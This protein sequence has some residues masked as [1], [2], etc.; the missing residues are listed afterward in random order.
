M[1]LGNPVNLSWD[2]GIGWQRLS[3]REHAM[4]TIKVIPIKAMEDYPECLMGG[5]KRK[6]K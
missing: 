2:N 5:V 3:L 1:M 6:R 4:C